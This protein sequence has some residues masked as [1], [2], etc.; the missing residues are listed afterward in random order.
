[1]QRVTRV[2]TYSDD[3]RDRL[4]DAAFTRLRTGDPDDMSLRDLAAQCHTSTNAIYTIFGG[5]DSLVEE[6]AA[7][8]RQDFL[9]PQI[10]LAT[11]AATLENFAQSGR[12][13]RAWAHANPGLYRLIFNVAS[14]QHKAF[15]LHQEMLDPVRQLL[16]RL[17]D[18]GVVAPHDVNDVALSLWA[19]THGFVMLEMNLWPRGSEDADRLFDVHLS[20]C[21]S[22][23]LRRP[24]VA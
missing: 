9:A 20:T 17:I 4:V 13:Y 3:L 18:P 8:A 6:V 14:G 23:I 1:M 7:M 11:R 2:R 19:S 22:G 10:D 15:S 12:L 24:R 5:K 21:V 16:R